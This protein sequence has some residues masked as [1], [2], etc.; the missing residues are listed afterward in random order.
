MQ[1]VILTFFAGCW[2]FDRDGGSG[3]DA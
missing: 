2:R 1:G 3:R